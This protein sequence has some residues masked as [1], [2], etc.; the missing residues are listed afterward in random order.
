MASK[1]YS[2]VVFFPDSDGSIAM[3][4]ATVFVPLLHP[5]AEIHSI[6][7]EKQITRH[8]CE[9]TAAVSS[10]PKPPLVHP[11]GEEHSS[12][13]RLSPPGRKI[14]L[15]RKTQAAWE[16]I[17]NE[18]RKETRLGRQIQPGEKEGTRNWHEILFL[19]RSLL[20]HASPLARAGVKWP[21]RQ[22]NVE[23]ASS[24]R[25]FAMACPPNY[26]GHQRR[27]KRAKKFSSAHQVLPERKARRVTSVSMNTAGILVVH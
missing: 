12:V 21:N 15:G 23:T 6:I 1:S 14:Q 8:S 27:T 4:A 26:M 11:S 17:T 5:A 18:V 10:R 9:I 7:T 22:A 13:E 20:F 24:S 25:R 19:K 3:N 16:R 2:A